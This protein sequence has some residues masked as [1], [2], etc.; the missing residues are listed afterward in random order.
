MVMYVLEHFGCLFQVFALRF[1]RHKDEGA[2]LIGCRLDKREPFYTNLR[3][4][5][6]FNHV[7]SYVPAG[8]N[9]T[10]QQATFDVINEEY[11]SLFEKNKINIQTV[12]K[13]YVF[14]DWQ[15]SLPLYLNIHGLEFVTVEPMMSG[16]AL[17]FTAESWH[18]SAYKSG[19]CSFAFY[20]LSRHLAPLDNAREGI[21]KLLIFPDTKLKDSEYIERF[22]F[23]G[24]FD[25]VCCEVKEKILNCFVFS[26][27]E[28]SC[29]QNRNVSLLLLSSSS[30]LTF[31]AGTTGLNLGGSIYTNNEIELV[32]AILCDYYYD[33]RNIL[34]FKPHPNDLDFGGDT[35]ISNGAIRMTIDMPI[36][37]MRW[38]PEL[39]IRQLLML[40]SSSEYKLEGFV[41]SRVAPG[42]EFLDCFR[43]LNKL[44]AIFGIIRSHISCRF[45][46]YYGVPRG[47]IE[48][49]YEINFDDYPC[50]HFESANELPFFD[51]NEIYIVNASCNNLTVVPSVDKGRLQFVSKPGNF[52]PVQHKPLLLAR[53]YASPVDCVIFFTNS[54]YE[55]CFADL[56][57]LDL[58]DFVVPIVIKKEV[59][60][61]N[62]L[63]EVHDDTI[64]VFAKNPQTRKMI[65]TTHLT[66]DLPF[67]GVRISTNEISGNRLMLERRKAIE[68]AVFNAASV[69][70][71][72]IN[73]FSS[74][75]SSNS[76]VLCICDETISDMTKQSLMKQTHKNIE[77]LEI[78]ANSVSSLTIDADY[79]LVPCEGMAYN[80]NFLSYL[81][82]CSPNAPFASASISVTRNRFHRFWV[83][84][85]YVNKIGDNLFRGCTLVKP[86][87]LRQSFYDASHNYAFMGINLVTID[88]RDYYKALLASK[89]ARRYY[90]WGA[91]FNALEI[92]LNIDLSHLEIR[93]IVDSNP[94]LEGETI[95]GVPIVNMAAI[96]DVSSYDA[97]LITPFEPEQEIYDELKK[98]LPTEKIVRLGYN[99]RLN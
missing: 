77:I 32:Y 30:T 94:L 4:S 88:I 13:A 89:E 12:N 7:V 26:Q 51:K 48:Q 50:R 46:N 97:V 1:Q 57:C 73:L 80:E 61:E 56:D 22:D 90:F 44:Y 6:L 79:V 45:V 84:G 64:F 81:L 54:L 70:L 74:I 39:R 87:L 43:Y 75:A 16:N 60:T 55:Y 63:D 86:E 96:E 92:L 58:L 67:S 10:T 53:L 5:G 29:F 17:R 31:Q 24:N 35:F 21:R 8:E 28:L 27:E 14:S 65:S 98:F 20:E 59:I 9:E 85:I 11:G 40:S 19:F 23:L 42:L 71:K 47:I 25:K 91:G 49:L 78:C 3:N 82:A 34:M 69:K 76:K 37:F 72:H 93:G 33:K 15:S 52:E 18:H 68:F 36:E 41:E 62:P 99:M 66:K 38:V 2:I 95:K 83:N